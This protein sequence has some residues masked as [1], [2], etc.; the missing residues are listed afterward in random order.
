M[1]ETVEPPGGGG[2]LGAGGPDEIQKAFATVKARFKTDV[3]ALSKLTRE[4][5]GLKDSLKDIN[6]ELTKMIALGADTKVALQGI[7]Q[8]GGGVGLPGPATGDGRSSPAGGTQGSEPS[9]GR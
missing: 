5:G 4:F 1:P 3:A 8:A 7:A 2:A 6:V 9:L